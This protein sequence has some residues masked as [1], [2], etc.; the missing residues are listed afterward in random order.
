MNSSSVQ[1]ITLKENHFILI[2]SMAMEGDNCNLC[3]KARND[4]VKVAGKFHNHKSIEI[5]HEVHDNLNVY[6]YSL[7]LGILKCAE[8]SKFCYEGILKVKYSRPVL[9]QVCSM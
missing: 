5:F 1:F 7:V 4:I 8:N 3:K 9:M 6:V 2:N